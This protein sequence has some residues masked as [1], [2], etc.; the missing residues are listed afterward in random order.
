MTL[1]LTATGGE[2]F[3]LTSPFGVF[4]HPGEGI[5]RGNMVVPS[6]GEVEDLRQLLQYQAVTIEVIPSA[7]YRR[8]WEVPEKG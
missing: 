2:V 7:P 5:T 8:E 1:H 4:E 6:L 3:R